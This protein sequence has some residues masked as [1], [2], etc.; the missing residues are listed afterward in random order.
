M[1]TS[2]DKNVTF[3]WENALS[4]EGDSGPYVQYSFARIKSIERNMISHITNKI[5]Y[6]RLVEIE[7]LELILE[8]SKMQDV[9]QTAMKQLSPHIVATYLFSVTQKFSK[10]YHNHSIL[11]ADSKELMDARYS[12]VLAVKQ[13]IVNCFSILG[14][15]A[16]EQM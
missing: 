2:N 14:I 10:F 9:I 4:F 16:L 12:L 3:D 1:K 11:K 15:E 8:I 6:E 5:Q 7:E 13:V